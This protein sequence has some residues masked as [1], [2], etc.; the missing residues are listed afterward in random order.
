MLEV[1]DFVKARA[2][3][4]RALRVHADCAAS[5]VRFELLRATV[6]SLTA[7]GGAVHVAR[8]LSVALPAWRL[9]SERGETSEDELRADLRNGLS[10]LV[11]SGDLIEA[12]GGRW[13]PAPTRLIP[14]KHG[15]G[16]LLVGGAPLSALPIAASDIQHH[17]PYRHVRPS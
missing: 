8:V 15:T 13:A 6:W 4:R 7:T 3:T 2:A 17:G 12:A 9:M 1:Y 11:D 14:L 16:R 10:S 5:D